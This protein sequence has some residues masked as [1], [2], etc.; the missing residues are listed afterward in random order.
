MQY[1]GNNQ[2]HVTQN[3]FGYYATIAPVMEPETSQPTISDKHFL[4]AFFFSF[5]WGAFGVDR[6]YLGKVGTGILKL[7]TFGG[8]G[9]WTIVDLVLIMSGSMHDSHDRVLK[10]YALY[11]GLAARTVILFAVITGLAVLVTGLLSIY[12]ISVVI[13]QFISGG[14]LDQLNKIQD[15]NQSQNLNAEDLNTLNL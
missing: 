12:I 3:G 9:I 10:D 11:K 1:S 5:M 4:A 13:N 2:S 14:G 15:L 6:F 7:I 8:F